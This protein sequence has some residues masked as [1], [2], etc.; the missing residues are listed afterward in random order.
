MYLLSHA[1]RWFD[2]TADEVKAWLSDYI[3]HITMDVII[4]PCLNLSQTMLEKT[5][6][7]TNADAICRH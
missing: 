1:W 4:L 3:S 7:W 6:S 2:Y 5:G